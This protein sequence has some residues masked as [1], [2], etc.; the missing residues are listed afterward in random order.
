MPIAVER[1]TGLLRRRPLARRGIQFRVDGTRLDVVD[2]DTP[3]PHLSGQPLTEHLDRSLRGRVGHQAGYH[4][5]LAHGRADHDDATAALHVLQRCLRR[6]QCSA[7]IDINHA[8]Q[9]L[10]RGFLESLGNGRAGIVDKHIKSAEGLDGLFD[11]GFDGAGISGVRL[12]C[13]RLA[14]TAFNLFDDRR[15]RVGAFRVCDRHVRSV[16]GQ[17]LGDCSANAARAARNEC[18]LSFQCLRHCFSS[19]C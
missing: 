3:A 10:Q 16:C 14:A 9:L 12:N 4:H 8:V 5:T 2:R 18:N 11:R 6:D 7:N 1:C 19:L 13:D 17:T 15:S